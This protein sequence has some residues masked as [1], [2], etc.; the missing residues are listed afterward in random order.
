MSMSRQATRVRLYIEENLE[1]RLDTDSLARVAYSSRAHFCRAFKRKFGVTVH[2]YVVQRRVERAQR[3]M[4]TTSA[5]L[6]EIAAACGMS[7]HSHLTRLFRRVVA[8]APSVWRKRNL[9]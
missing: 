2:S 7:D 9:E 8:E 6:T 3:L 1:H 4:L 5:T